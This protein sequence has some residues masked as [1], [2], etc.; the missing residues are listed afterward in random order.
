VFD[1]IAVFESGDC[2][3]S[4]LVDRPAMLNGPF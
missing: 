2:A 3:W 4:I 1:G